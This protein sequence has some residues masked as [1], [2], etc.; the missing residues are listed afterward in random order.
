MIIIFCL[1][2]DIYLFQMSKNS[3]NNNNNNRNDDNKY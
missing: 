2:P 3:N 1:F